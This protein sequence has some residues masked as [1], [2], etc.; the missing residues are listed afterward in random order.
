[1]RALGISFVLV[2]LLV[3]A[4]GAGWLGGGKKLPKPIKM[5][6]IRAHDGARL[7]KAS[8]IARKHDPNW[9]GLDKVFYKAQRLKLHPYLRS[10]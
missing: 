10:Y 5:V 7:N 4:A 3:P 6:E 2:L 9:G 8:K 1:M